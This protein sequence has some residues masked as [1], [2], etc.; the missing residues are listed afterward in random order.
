M[1]SLPDPV[2]ILLRTNATA[3]MAAML[4]VSVSHRELFDWATRAICGEPH[5]IE[6]PAAARRRL[7]K[8]NGAAHKPAASRGPY[9]AR[10]RAQRDRDHEGLLEAMRIAP[11]ASIGDWA[12]A[13][14][15]SRSSAVSALHRLRDAGLVEV[16]EGRWRVIEPGAPI[17]PPPKWVAPVRGA[18]RAQQHHLT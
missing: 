16:V 17:A 15:K 13:I 7:R 1:S 3:A 2:S 18:D 14:G 10:R 8:S 12:T 11:G 5:E 6:P 9:L 4:L